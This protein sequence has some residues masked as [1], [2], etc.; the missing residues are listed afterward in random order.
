M[1]CTYKRVIIEN[2]PPIIMCCME[3]ILNAAQRVRKKVT[4]NKVLR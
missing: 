1:Y 4:A 3:L 2:V